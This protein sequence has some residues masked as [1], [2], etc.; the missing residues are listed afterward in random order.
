MCFSKNWFLHTFRT[1]LAEAELEYNG[2]HES[3]AILLGVPLTVNAGDFAA[4]VGTSL[5]AECQ[6]ISDAPVEAVVWTTTPW[7]LPANAAIAYNDKEE[8]TLLY[9]KDPHGK[10]KKFYLVATECVPRF[11]AEYGQTLLPAIRFHGK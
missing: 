9:V 3:T 10:T 5:P 6:N 2:A 1:A 8:Y 11:Q 7:S 4:A